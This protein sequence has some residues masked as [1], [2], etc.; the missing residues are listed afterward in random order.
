MYPHSLELNLSFQAHSLLYCWFGN[1]HCQRLQVHWGRQRVGIAITPSCLWCRQGQVDLCRICHTHSIGS[2]WIFVLHRRTPLRWNP[3]GTHLASDVL[4]GHSASARPY[5][6]RCQVPGI[7]TT[8]F[9]LWNFGYRTLRRTP[10]LQCV[11]E[12]QRS[13]VA[14]INK[15][16]LRNEKG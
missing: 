16:K 1:C 12:M 10:W 4:P 15:N 8:I 6:E 13:D 5:W 2:C 14:V 3:H 11:N 9:G 7:G